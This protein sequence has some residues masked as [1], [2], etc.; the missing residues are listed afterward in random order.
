VTGVAEVATLDEFVKEYQV[1][2]DPAKLLAYGV[3]AR[4]VIDAVRGAN[5]DVGAGTVEVAGSD[6]AIRG[7]GLYRGVGD[8]ARAAV[9]VGRA[10]VGVANLAF[11]PR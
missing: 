5:Q 3:T 8:I 10:V 7:L 1:L 9:G 2:L 11:P 4:Q 6:Y